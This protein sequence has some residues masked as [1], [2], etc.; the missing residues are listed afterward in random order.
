MVLLARA[1]R[2]LHLSRQV[3]MAPDGTA[4]VYVHTGQ[5][6]CRV[7]TVSPDGGQLGRLAAVNP[8]EV[9]DIQWSPDGSQ[10]ILVW[11]RVWV[12]QS[13]WEKV[14]PGVERPRPGAW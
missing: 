6:T 2:R 12:F 3:E 1:F 7:L 4:I 13:P 9:T 11:S 5:D 10:V 8:G 14:T